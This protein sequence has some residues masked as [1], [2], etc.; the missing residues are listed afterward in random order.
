[1]SQKKNQKNNVRFKIACSD[2]T[3]FLVLINNTKNCMSQNDTTIFFEKKLHL[4]TQANLT[5]T[6]DYPLFCLTDQAC[7]NTS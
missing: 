2:L 3:G 6:L 1:M 7:S 4:G 5:D